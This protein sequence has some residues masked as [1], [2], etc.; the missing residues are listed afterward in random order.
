MTTPPDQLAGD[1]SLPAS[2]ARRPGYLPRRRAPDVLVIVFAVA[3]ALLVVFLVL[4]LLVTIATTAPGALAD[5]LG[6]E[7][8]LRSLILTFSAG[9][10]AT[11][12]AGL[13]GVPL[14]Y[15][16]ARKH[17]FGQRIVE[18]MIDLPVVV[19]HT[20]A[21]IALLMVFGSQGL[22][23]GPLGLV[24][25]R[26]LDSLWG[27]V[28]AMMFVGA[29]FLVSTA[30]E[31][32]RMVDPKL[33][34]SALTLGAGEWEAF[35]YI[36]LPLA[37]RGVVAGAL[38]MWARGISE[39]GAVVIIAYYPKI[40]PVLIYERFQAFGLDAAKPAAAILIFA[41]LVV[42]TVLRVLLVR[43]KPLS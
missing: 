22:I 16:L 8:I 21:G 11:V 3:G 33:E 15:L 27:I 4:P 41:S 9:A 28:V 10:I 37:W 14:S 30:R 38:M 25:V 5:T 34:R 31:S 32:F 7:E 40:M 26:F 2:P 18:S 20:A 39:F 23:G 43:R 12:I 6:D 1:A 13:L 17:F 19:P 36:T 24:G 42:F 29:P 35:V